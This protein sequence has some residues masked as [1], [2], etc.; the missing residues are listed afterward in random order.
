[1][2]ILYFAALAILV[3]VVTV[4]YVHLFDVAFIGHDFA[5]TALAVDKVG[6]IIRLNHKESGELLDFGSS[7]GGFIF[8]LLKVC[9]KL[10][11]VGVDS[12]QFRIW[13]SKVKNF[14]FLR[15]AVFLK[16]N[17][18]SSDVCRAD[19]VYVYLKPSE[20]PK[21][22]AKLKA[23]L[24]PGAMVIVNTQ[25]FANWPAAQTHI[26][27]RQKPDYEKLSVYLQP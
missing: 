24:K 9:P 10:K 16:G 17:A 23:Q 12:S 2:V 8:R 25:S 19:V 14:L 21:I 5:T 11:A 4:F 22:E 18:Y 3:A 26:V 15:H 7:R 1:M 27:H 20:M 6:E 13:Q